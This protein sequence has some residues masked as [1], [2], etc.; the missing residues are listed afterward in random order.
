MGRGSMRIGTFF[1][2]GLYVHWTFL[3]LIAFVA[4]RAEGG[5]WA[6]IDSVLL[7]LGVFACVVLHEYGHALTAKRFGIRTRD[8]TLLPIGGVARLERMPREPV[9]ELVIAVAGPAVNVVIALI[10]FPI[11]L[12]TGGMERA[13]EMSTLKGVDVPMLLAQLMAINVAL[14]LFNMIP[15][16]P[17][18]GGRVLRALLAMKLAYAKATRAAAMVGSVVAGLFLIFGFYSGNYMLML[19]AAFVWIVG[20][21]EARMAERQSAIENLRVHDAMIT[22]F[23]ALRADST[24][25]EALKALLAGLQPDFPVV[26]AAGRTVGVLSRTDLLRAIASSG[27]GATVGSAMRRDCPVLH[28]SDLLEVAVMQMRETQCP[29][30]PVVRDGTLVGV[31]AM[32]NVSELIMARDAVNAYGRHAG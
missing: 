15:A 26:D 24:L 22:R 10:L 3:L 14:V 19:I 12:A 5:L 6:V 2:I 16:F 7:V 11:V 4:F 17:M 13:A 31:L 20:S 28:E 27:P 23:R 25:D 8:I 9:R 1:G 29:I 18:D 21:A 32:E 30:L